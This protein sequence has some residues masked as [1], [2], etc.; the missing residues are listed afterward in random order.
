[1]ALLMQEYILD[2]LKNKYADFNGRARR[3]EFWMLFLFISAFNVV[4]GI[5]VQVFAKTSSVTVFDLLYGVVGLALL[6]PY[7]ASIV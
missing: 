5:L 7:F 4:F 6:I 1:V 2:V 3:K